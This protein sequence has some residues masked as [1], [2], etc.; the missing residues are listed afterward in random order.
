[1]RALILILSAAVV[2]LAASIVWHVDKR[3]EFV[4]RTGPLF[5]VGGLLN[6]ATKG[7]EAVYR[8]KTSQRLT[9]FL[10]VDAPRLLPMAVPYKRIRR[11]VRD[12]R[13]GTDQVGD[14]VTYDHRLT[15]HGWFPLTAPDAP[16][17][18]DRVWVIR[19]IEPDTLDLGTEQRACWRVDLIDPALPEGS[20]T[21]VAWVDEA[22]PVFGLLKWKRGGKTWE[23]VSGKKAP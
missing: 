21:V 18:L 5:Y 23:F 4:T 13:A 14:S 22:V 2:G 1:M 19:G 12:P 16:D 15:E 11:E 3:P 9:R 10:V 20:D 6:D 8:E 7:E 17:A